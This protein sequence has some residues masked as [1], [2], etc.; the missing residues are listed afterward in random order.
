MATRDGPFRN[1]L[2]RFK[3]SLTQHEV[4]DFGFSGL[5]QIHKVMQGKKEE[6]DESLKNEFIP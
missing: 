4:D 5:E 2:A 3:L 6:S 1:V